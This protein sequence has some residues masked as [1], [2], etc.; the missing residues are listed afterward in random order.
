M[1]DA[2]LS[3]ALREAYA[4]AK[5]V[6]ILHT[7][8]FRHPNFTTPIRVVLDRKDWDLK[9]EST[10][11]VDPGQVVTWIGYAFEF[12]LPEALGMPEIEISID[13]VSG[14]IVQYLDLAA[15]SPDYIEVTYRA[16]LA[17]DTSGPQND[18]PLTLIVREV[19]A[20]T[21]RVRARCGFGD[22]ANRKFPSEVY[23][24]QRFPGLAA[25]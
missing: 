15:Q 23:D 17:D 21:Y 14:D 8:E 10:A 1:P 20:D 5:P 6:Q 16:Y 4:N 9:L 19:S 2:T 18:P 13:N 3:Q 22:L 12:T 24:L 25:V 11:P 7:L